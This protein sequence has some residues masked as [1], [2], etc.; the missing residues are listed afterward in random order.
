MNTS[1]PEWDESGVKVGISDGRG[2]NFIFVH[3][4][5]GNGTDNR[6][7]CL[8]LQDEHDRQ[9]ERERQDRVRNFKRINEI[10]S[11]VFAYQ[12]VVGRQRKEIARLKQELKSQSA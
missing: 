9:I 12:G 8:L 7:L 6:N 10:E 2:I 1:R 4:R 5:A 11:R 3:S